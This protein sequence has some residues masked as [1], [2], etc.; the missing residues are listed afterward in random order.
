MMIDLGHVS[1]RCSIEFVGLIP[2]LISGSDS[3]F[4]HKCAIGS[5]LE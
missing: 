5:N 2:F 3:F 4:M 1:D